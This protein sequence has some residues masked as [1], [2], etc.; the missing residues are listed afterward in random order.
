MIVTVEGTQQGLAASD[1]RHEIEQ[2]LR[3]GYLDGVMRQLSMS[4]A[5][6]P[7]HD[8]EDATAYAVSEAIKAST[9][10]RPI[11]DIKKYLYVVARNYLRKRKNNLEQAIYNPGLHEEQDRSA[12]DELMMRELTKIIW[13]MIDSWE[14]ARMRVITRL[15]L[16][17]AIEGMHL[18]LAEAAETATD[19]LGELVPMSAVATTRNR[20]LSR[21]AKA[22]E[23][24]S[25]SGAE[26]IIVGWDI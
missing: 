23:D 5:Q 15:Y 14:S 13:K 19:I 26:P 17:A 6:L 7:W 9:G 10:G 22:L 4:F 8:A 3:A 2:L 20:G 25:P 21:L 24:I 18:P 11:H 12:D 16:E 1:L